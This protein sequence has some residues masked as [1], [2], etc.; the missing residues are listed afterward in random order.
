MCITARLLPLPY[1]KSPYISTD[2][3]ECKGAPSTMG[4]GQYYYNRPAPECQ[5]NFMEVLFE[6]IPDGIRFIYET[7]ETHRKALSDISDE[8]TDYIKQEKAERT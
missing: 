2:Q 1:K 5:E 3:S 7:L 6:S 8:L 4:A